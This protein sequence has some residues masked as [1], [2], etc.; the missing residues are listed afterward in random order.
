MKK[1]AI[2]HLESPENLFPAHELLVPAL[3]LEKA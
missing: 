2:M 1:L 3:I